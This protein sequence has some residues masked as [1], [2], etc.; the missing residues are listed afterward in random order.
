LARPETKKRKETKKVIAT[1]PD[2]EIQKAEAERKRL[3]PRNRFQFLWD[4]FF[5]TR[6]FKLSQEDLLELEAIEKNLSKWGEASNRIWETRNNPQEVFD[7]YAGRYLNEPSEENYIAMMAHS[8]SQPQ[9]SWLMG[10]AGDQF[11]SYLN[12]ERE[13]LFPPLVRKHLT[14]IYHSLLAEYAEQEKADRKSLARLEGIAS[15]GESQACIELRNRAEQI[16]QLLEGGNL[17]DWRSA[18]GAFLP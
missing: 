4:A 8:F 1:L 10:R 6:K 7:K 2:P 15:G 5:R 16:R 13:R 9:H 11:T 12:G 18:L 14:R 3:E 17:S